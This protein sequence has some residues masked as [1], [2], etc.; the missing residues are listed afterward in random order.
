MNTMMIEP[1]ASMVAGLCIFVMP[2]LL[3]YIVAFYLLLT[4]FVELLRA[5]SPGM[6]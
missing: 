5:M 6:I 1:I 2:H 3:S 4:G